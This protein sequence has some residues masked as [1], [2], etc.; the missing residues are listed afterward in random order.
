MS[1]EYELDEL[2]WRQALLVAQAPHPSGLASWNGSDVGHR[3]SVYRN[4]VVSSLIEALADTFPS[5]RRALGPEIF[6]ALA[7]RYASHNPPA[8]PGLYCYGDHFPA[9]LG[10]LLP[11]AQ[12]GWARDL[13]R[14]ELAYLASCHAA[15]TLAATRA[16]WQ[17]LL[18]NPALLTQCRPRLQAAVQLISVAWEVW[19]LWQ[20]EGESLVTPRASSHWLCLWRDAEGVKL[21]PLQ[22]PSAAGL[23]Q[24]QL[25]A[26]L[27]ESLAAVHAAGGAVDAV[28]ASWIQLELIRSP[29]T[30]PLSDDGLGDM[31]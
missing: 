13:A 5:V 20:K 28:L 30:T 21:A 17:Q 18:E 16:Q 23:R 31:L 1:A 22:V 12:A 15:D 24:L 19:P 6:D 10:G 9:W 4:N 25:G 11:L 7:R 8:S 26:S 3:F 14:L 27:A 2:A 29:L